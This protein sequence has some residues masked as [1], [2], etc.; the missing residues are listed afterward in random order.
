MSG[1]EQFDSLFAFEAYEIGR[2]RIR[3]PHFILGVRQS[4]RAEID[5]YYLFLIMF[6]NV[7]TWKK[8]GDIGMAYAIAYYSKLGY[9]ISIPLTDSQDYDFIIDTGT[10]LLKVQVKT[11]TQVSNRGVPIV[12][13]RTNGGNR[14]G[15][16]KE[17]T[18]DI[19]SSDLLFVLLEN[20]TC[21]SIPTK[22]ITSKTAINLGEKY[23]P[24]KVEL[25]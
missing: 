3:C 23:L 11:S 17:K 7:T 12:S 20:G 2:S 10:N 22:N 8:Q 18:F 24:Y 14:S 6:K 9:T 1:I 21:Y 15:Q 19:N 16:G 5:F 4:W 25:F 13:L